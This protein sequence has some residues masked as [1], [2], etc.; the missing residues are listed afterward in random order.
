MNPKQKRFADEYLIDL[1]AT[2][3]YKRAGYKGKG[4]V[5]EV[6]ASR[7]L[8]N[9]KVAH[10]VK[11]A[12][13]KVTGITGITVERTLQ[14]LGRLAYSDP[15]KFY[16]S[17]GNLKPIHELDDDCAACVA[18]IEIDEIKADGNVIGYTKKLKHWDKNSALE[19]AMKYLKMVGNDTP[20]PVTNNTLVIMDD[21]NRLEVARRLAFVLARGAKMV[22]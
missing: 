19:K 9:A 17:Q 20:A 8:S 15:R 7:M 13:D 18:S 4:N 10:Y 12:L 16:D 22:K 1:N 3:A 11:L 14:E 6:N 5:A 21:N 2:A